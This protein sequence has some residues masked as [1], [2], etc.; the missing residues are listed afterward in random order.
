MSRLVFKSTIPDRAIAAPNVPPSSRRGSRMR[1]RQCCAFISM[2]VLGTLGGVAIWWALQGR[3]RLDETGGD[4]RDTAEVEIRSSLPLESCYGTSTF[5]SANVQH[6]W[7]SAD[8]R[9]HKYLGALYTKAQGMGPSNVLLVRGDE[10][11]EA[12]A[13]TRRAFA[14]GCSAGVPINPT[15]EISFA[16]EWLVAYMGAEGTEPP[17]WV[18]HSVQVTDH[19]LRVVYSQPRDGGKSDDMHHYYLWV[20]LGRLKAGY[21]DL[22]LF[23][24]DKQHVSLSRRVLVREDD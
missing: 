2:A 5:G 15:E 4:T 20:P 9:V 17:A 21:Y 1:G 22:E 23:D 13:T 8:V 11:L 14:A 3:A 10:I 7:R 16:Q 24:D 12:I 19:R 18:I 6:L